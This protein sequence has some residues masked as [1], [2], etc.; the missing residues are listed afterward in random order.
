L[1]IVVAVV[2]GI[3]AAGLEIVVAVVAGITAAGLEIVV[4]VVAGV[5]AAGLEI[6]VAVV[7]VVTAAGLEI[8]VAV[9]AGVVAA[10]LEI[11]VA[12]VAGVAAV[13]IAGEGTAA[14]TGFAMI[15][16]ATSG[17]GKSA[18]THDSPLDK[19]ANRKSIKRANFAIIR[20]SFL[21]RRQRLSASFLFYLRGNSRV[22]SKQR[23]NNMP[24][25][26]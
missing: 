12:V 17:A 6:V 21:H 9:V 11:V 20:S 18:A 2:A 15:A 1:E 16:G 5:V 7:A 13:V 26:N 8:V 4:A 3:T 24:P 23:E 22:G 10:G 19:P 14:S 25:S